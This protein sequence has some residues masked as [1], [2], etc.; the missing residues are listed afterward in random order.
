MK[1]YLYKEWKQNRILFLLTV[2]VAICVAFMPI[3]LIMAWENVVSKEVFLVFSYKGILFQI[4]C[5]ALGFMGTLGVQGLTLR[6]DERRSWGYFVASNPKGIKG[7]IL[8]KYVMIALLSVVFFTVSAVCDFIFTLIA[9]TVGGIDIPTI[10]ETLAYLMMIQVLIQAVE[11]PFSIR[12]GVK[13]GNTIKN[14]LFLSIIV[15][16][17]LIFILN[18][19]GVADFCSRI[20]TDWKLPVFGKWVL[21]VA[22]VIVYMLSYLISCKLY[23]KG[24]NEAYK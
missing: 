9:K 17:I 14:I 12:F 18:P 24:V 16:F 15:I 5:V 11:I 2:I 22:S 7:Y 10:T 20:E 4:L 1:G 13:K 8:A 23:L 3:L 6:D 19:E 21:P